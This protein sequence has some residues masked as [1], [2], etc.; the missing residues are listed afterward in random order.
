MFDGRNNLARQVATD[1]R[2]NFGDGV[3]QAVVPRNVRLSEAPSFG[4]PS[5]LYDINSTGCKSYI[6][7]AREFM[8]KHG[9]GHISVRPDHIISEAL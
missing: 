6:Q 8:N 7:L 4:K 3:F 2:S 5:I 9:L 1:V